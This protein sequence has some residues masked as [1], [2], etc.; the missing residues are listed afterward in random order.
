MKAEDLESL[1]VYAALRHGIDGVLFFG[2]KGLDCRPWQCKQTNKTALADMSTG[3]YVN[4]VF[5]PAAQKAVK[6]AQKCAESLCSGAGRCENCTTPG[7]GFAGCACDCDEKRSGAKC[8]MK[9]D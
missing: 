8:E 5:G 3:K 6:L 4:T 1:F 2:A 7:S 9:A